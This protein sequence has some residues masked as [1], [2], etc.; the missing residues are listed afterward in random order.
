[1][2]HREGR[3]NYAD[4]VRKMSTHQSAGRVGKCRDVSAGMEI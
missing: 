4:S 1:M 3:L 2:Q